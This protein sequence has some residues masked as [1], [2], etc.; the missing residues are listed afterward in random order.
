MNNHRDVLSASVAFVLIAEKAKC[1][2]SATDDP[3]AKQTLME[4]YQ[5]AVAGVQKLRRERLERMIDYYDLA[6]TTSAATLQAYSFAMERE[7]VRRALQV[8][9][10][11][12]MHKKQKGGNV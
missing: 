8:M 3:E 12:G 9:D 7:D 2:A 5:H 4:I 11:Q 1:R 10:E 6:A